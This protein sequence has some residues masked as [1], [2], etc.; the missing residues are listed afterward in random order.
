[1]HNPFEIKKTVTNKLNSE[2]EISKQIHILNIALCL[3]DYQMRSQSC[4][5][6]V[7]LLL[8]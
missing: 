8:T 6:V 5:F 4:A 2:P 3:K 1:M 7:A